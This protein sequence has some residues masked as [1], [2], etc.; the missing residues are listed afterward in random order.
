MSTGLTFGNRIINLDEVTS[1]NSYAQKLAVETNLIEGLVVLAKNQTAGKGQ[2]GNTWQVEP[3]KNLT[4]SLLLTPNIAV[5]EQFMLSKAIALGLFDFLTA[6]NLKSVAIKWPNDILVNNKKIAGILIENTL[7]ANK[8][9]TSIVGVGLN[10]N[11]Q[12][13]SSNL[14]ATSLQNELNINFDIETLFNDLLICLEKRYLMLRALQYQKINT[15]YLANLLGYNTE[16]NYK[17]GENPCKGIIRGVNPLG[18]LQLEINGKIIEFDLKEVSL[19][20]F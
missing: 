10:V 18:L 13:F 4:F 16:L 9:S 11:Q 15:D 19:I 17:V 8:I 2:R 3:G 1:T 5:N 7:K 20:G 14:N 6:L 12:A